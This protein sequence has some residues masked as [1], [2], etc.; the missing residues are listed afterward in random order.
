MPE[1][2]WRVL[3]A[4]PLFLAGAAAMLLGV[5]GLL[6][7]PDV[8][9]RLHALALSELG[10]ALILLGFAMIA[11]SPAQGLL[12]VGLGLGGVVL[13]A[14]VRHAVAEA[15]RAAGLA[16]RLGTGEQDGSSA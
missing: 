3:L 8:Y 4:A 5:L 12:L 13:G 10:A 14:A 16:P 7:L 1:F 6:R 11:A 15:A 2:D 9:T